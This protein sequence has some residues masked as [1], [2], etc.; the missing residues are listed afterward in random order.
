LVRG[1]RDDDVGDSDGLEASSDASAGSALEVPALRIVYSI[2]RE[3]K[4]G[5]GMAPKFFSKNLED[6]LIAIFFQKISDSPNSPLFI[7]DY[8]NNNV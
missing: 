1:A 4:L 8:I 5:K 3:K 2:A 7:L 6:L